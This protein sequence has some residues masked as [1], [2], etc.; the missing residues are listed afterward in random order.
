MPLLA[1]LAVALA[2]AEAATCEWGG[3][4][5]LRG[6]RLPRATGPSRLGAVRSES[7]S[8]VTAGAAELLW[9]GW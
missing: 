8:A 9:S 5:G 6:G 7:R 3:G 2:L 1:G 4:R